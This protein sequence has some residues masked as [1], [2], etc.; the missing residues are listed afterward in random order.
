MFDTINSET[1]WLDT[2]NAILGL[3]TAICL[4]IV[5]RVAFKEVRARIAK[6][7][8]VP[9]A[10]DSHAFNLADLGITMADGGAPID[11]TT[12]TGRFLPEETSDPSNIFRSNN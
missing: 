10:E 11:E 7:S 9:L 2:T 8:R 3:V 5:G 1:F 4:A 12:H 6:R